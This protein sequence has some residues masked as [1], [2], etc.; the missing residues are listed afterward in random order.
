MTTL[1]PLYTIP[2]LASLIGQDRGRVRRLLD[3][4]GVKYIDAGTLLVPLVAFRDAFPALWDSIVV[5]LDIDPGAIDCP[6][7]G[8][9]VLV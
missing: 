1:K 8:G 4:R 2:E 5:R 3:R 6:V 9:E 7:C